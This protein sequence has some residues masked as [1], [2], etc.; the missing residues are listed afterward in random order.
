MMN[1]PLNWSAWIIIS[2]MCIAIY[3]FFPSNLNI[4]DYN[5]ELIIQGEYWRLITGNFNHTNHYHLLLNLAALLTI[6]G[7]HR[8]HYSPLILIII[9]LYLSI[10]VGSNIL[11]FSPSVSLYVGLS[12]LLHGLI[13]I[14][15]YMDIVKGQHSGWLLLLGTVAKVIYEQVYNNTEQ[16]SQLIE[17]QV[18]TAAHMYGLIAGLVTYPIIR[19]MIKRS[20]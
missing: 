4:V 18:L 14:G 6:A 1:N 2:L 11:L 12:G 13:V 5:R 9:M 8:H 19:H 7:L 15:S 16:V 17:A 3:F 10:F 20:I